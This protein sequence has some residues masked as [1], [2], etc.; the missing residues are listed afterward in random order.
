MSSCVVVDPPHIPSLSRPPQY[1][2]IEAV[3]DICNGLEETGCPRSISVLSEG[4][5][6]SKVIYIRHET[7]EIMKVQYQKDEIELLLLE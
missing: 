1:P 4:F 5:G 6:A 2:S 7:I 3:S